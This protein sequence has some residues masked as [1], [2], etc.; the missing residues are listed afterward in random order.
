MLVLPFL[1]E[2]NMQNSQLSAGLRARVALEKHIFKPAHSLGQNFIL[3]D[4]FLSLLLDLADVNCG[5]RVLEIGPGP[6]VMTAL[7]ADR[8]EK[9]LAIEMDEKLKPVLEDVLSGQDK[10]KVLFMDAMRADLATL[11]RDE[12]GGEGY[13]VVANLPYYITADLIQKMV[14]TRPRPQ[15]VC[16]MVQKEAAERL[17]SEPG[18]KNWCAFAAMVRCYG[19]CEVLDEVP[20]Q[21]FNPAPHVDSCFI[22]IH[23]HDQHLVEPELEEALLKMVRCCFH[24]RRKTLAN[25]LK[26]CYGINQEQAVRVLEEA[27]LKPQ[28]RGEAL[29]LEEIARLTKVM[30]I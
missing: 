29:T 11:V 22:R 27:G 25:N 3:D 30:G 10:A 26:A 28:V 21:R 19:E 18:A 5:D 12:L 8:A 16:V 14:L 24:M 1:K 23:L 2:Q 9:V 15:S 13:R 4:G 6:G 20:P 7:L 17:M